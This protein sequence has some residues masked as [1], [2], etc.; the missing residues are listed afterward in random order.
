MSGSIQLVPYDA[1][2][3][4]M[5]AHPDGKVI[6]RKRAEGAKGMLAGRQS[7]QPDTRKYTGRGTLSAI[8]G[9]MICW[10]ANLKSMSAI[11]Q[12]DGHRRLPNCDCWN[13]RHLE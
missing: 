6:A 9:S 4:R 8:T 12:Q 11:L 1:N 7:V 5:D 2:F 13:R 10:A 3:R